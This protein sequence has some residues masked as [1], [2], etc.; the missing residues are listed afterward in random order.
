MDSHFSLVALAAH[1]TRLHNFEPASLVL[2]R[3]HW[4]YMCYAQNQE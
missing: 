2:H 1:I 4:G 3:A